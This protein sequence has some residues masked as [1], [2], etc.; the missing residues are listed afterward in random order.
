MELQVL[1]YARKQDLPP[2]GQ[3]MEPGA[4]GRLQGL[5][6]GVLSCELFF[7]FFPWLV[8]SPFVDSERALLLTGYRTQWVFFGVS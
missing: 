4:V 3:V 7:P 5:G 8:A 1:V 6:L 2:R